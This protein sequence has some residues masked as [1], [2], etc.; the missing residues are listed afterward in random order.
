MPN[1]IEDAKH[2]LRDHLEKNLQPVP[3]PEDIF[4]VWFNYSVGSW[5]CEM[6]T[7]DCP[8]WL[9]QV[10]HNPNALETYL[11]VYKK[12]SNHVYMHNGLDLVEITSKDAPSRPDV[13]IPNCPVCSRAMV[14][15][16]GK[17]VCNGHEET[18]NEETYNEDT[19]MK[20]D[21]AL[22]NHGLPVKDIPD[23]ILSMQN[24]GI[25]FRERV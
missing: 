11:D 7:R 12:E 24:A 15:S 9:F 25:L 17:F 22:R 19:L 13:D 8:G 23:I 21:E 10:T 16:Q 6:A 14:W 1:P 20:V 18:Y 2:I 3:E 4:V 5:K